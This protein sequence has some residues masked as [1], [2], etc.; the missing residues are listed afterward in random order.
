[1]ANRSTADVM[2]SDAICDMQ[3]RLGSRDQLSRLEARGKWKADVTE[4]VARFIAS[5][6]SCFLGTATADGQPYIQHRGGEAGFI[7]MIGS[8]VLEFPDFAGNRHYMTLGNLSENPSAFLFMI[9]YE[10]GTRV[11]FWGRAEIIGLETAARA[12]RFTIDAWDVNCKKHIP[13]LI[14]RN[15]KSR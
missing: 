3:K 5:R 7:R 4:D 6:D 8:R 15:S 13:L 10:T 9:D 1:M 2:F 14:G 11:K 12:I